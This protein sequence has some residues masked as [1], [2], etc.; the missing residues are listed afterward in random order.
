MEIHLFEEIVII[1]ALSTF[2]NLIF[3]RVK[4]PA[5]I[6]FLLT[7]IL[8]GPYAFGLI[9][10]E[11]VHDIEIL[12][13]IGVML[14]LFTIGIEFSIKNLVQIRRTVLLGGSLQVGLTIVAFYFISRVVGLEFGPA[15]FMGF[16]ISLSSTAIVL[17]IIQ[18]R[19]EVST[20]HGRTALG[21]LIFQ[22]IIIVPM[23][24]FTPMLAGKVDN[25]ANE[26]LL[27]VLKAIGLIGFTLVAS[28]WLVPKLLHQIART[29]SQE[30]FLL[31]LLFLGF[32]IAWLTSWLGLSLAFGA[33]LAGL[34]ISET[35]YKHQAFGNIMPIRDIFT[36]FFFVSIGMLLD[37]EFFISQPV[38]IVGIALGVIFLKTI[39]A[40]FVAFVLGYPFKTTITVGL[41]LSQVGEFSF[42]LSKI[43]IDNQLLGHY[44]YQL[45]LSVTIISMSAAPFIIMGARPLGKF[46]ERILPLSLRI[47]NGLRPVPDVDVEGDLN[48][49]LIIVGMGL[50]GHNLARAAKMANI[51]YI[52]I[53]TDA[54]IVR[55]ESAKGE[56]IFFGDAEQESVLQHAHISTAKILVTVIA[57]S[58][59]TYSIVKLARKLNPSLHLITRTRYVSDVED[60]F[61]AGAN[62]V[63]PEEFETSV[64]IFARVLS[65]YLIPKDDIEK[66]MADVRASGYQMFRAAEVPS[67]AIVAD[68]KA[69]MPDIEI[70]TVKVSDNS[71]I[72][73][74]TL[75]EV[76]LRKNYGI[77]LLAITRKKR[78]VSSPDPG[79]VFA[80]GDLLYLLGNANQ[81][82][83]AM[84][85]F[86]EQEIPTCP[87]PPQNF[88]NNA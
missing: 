12:A 65:K 16:L 29:Q 41:I 86:R 74:K 85:L 46:F 78:T 43:G 26:V 23:I 36:S 15:L 33:F 34:T 25:L 67:S 84:S 73:G 87:T 69:Q 88:E 19:A 57:E 44:H 80:A 21:I 37:L 4:V 47:I 38:L 62:E 56:P 48:N 22:D 5:I 71:A 82:A 7:G 58:A 27:L 40:G 59:S 76:E 81:V 60:L 2:V 10:H 30:L 1:F 42:V 54:D 50:N 8:A 45:F 64:E 55:E 49:H 28:R 3:Q 18:Q 77:N 63:I 79:I 17:K 68:L 52:I 32:A 75:Y 51:D 11:Y 72:V 35:E 24:L 6:G 31:S 70:T 20:H 9:G 39:I 61:A 14:L 13:E 53:D 66:L 83:C